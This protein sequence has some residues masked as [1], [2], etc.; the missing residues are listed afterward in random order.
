MKTSFL[1]LLAV[2]DSTAAG[3]FRAIEAFLS[4]NMIQLKNMV[5]FTS[6]GAEVMMG[7]YN[8]VQAK[9][10]VHYYMHVTVCLLVH[11]I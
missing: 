2:K 6:D 4:R 7:K 1:K 10:N 8:G 3:L 11:Y 5:M 9:I